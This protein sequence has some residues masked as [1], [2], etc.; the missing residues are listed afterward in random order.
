MYASLERLSHLT[1]SESSP[2][3]RKFVGL[4]RDADRLPSA[5]QCCEWHVTD[6]SIPKKTSGASIIMGNIDRYLFVPAIEWLHNGTEHE[7]IHLS[8]PDSTHSVLP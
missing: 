5:G 2:A 7:H 6:F 1:I 8:V 3:C 4:E